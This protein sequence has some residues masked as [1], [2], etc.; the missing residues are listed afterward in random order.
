MS[1]RLNRRNTHFRDSLVPPTETSAAIVKVDSTQ[2][3]GAA[4]LPPLT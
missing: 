2:M 4:D 1:H 3:N